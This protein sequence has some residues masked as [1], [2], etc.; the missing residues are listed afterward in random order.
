MEKKKKKEKEEQKGQT[1]VKRPLTRVKAII[2][3]SHYNIRYLHTLKVKIKNIFA[4]AS[5]RVCIGPGDIDNYKF[6]Q[7]VELLSKWNI[8]TCYSPVFE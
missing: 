5:F 4:L 1:N 3:S 2:Y 8:P 7:D 6:M